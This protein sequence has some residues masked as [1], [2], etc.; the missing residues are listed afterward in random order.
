MAWREKPEFT[1]SSPFIP[2]LHFYRQGIAIS[3]KA[4]YEK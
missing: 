1:R 2:T 3:Q 4:A